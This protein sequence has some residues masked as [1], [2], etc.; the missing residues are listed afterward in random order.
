MKPESTTPSTPDTAKYRLMTADGPMGPYS[1][2]ELRLLVDESVV[3]PSMFA[4][5]EESIEQLPLSLILAAP[6]TWMPPQVT[7]S[8]LST[9]FEVEDRG[10][11]FGPYCEE[12]IR[13]MAAQGYFSF[14]ALAGPFG[15]SERWSLYKLLIIGRTFRESR[16]RLIRNRG[17]RLLGY[18]V[19]ALFVFASFPSWAVA[20]AGHADAAA[21]ASFLVIT[22]IYFAART[23][24][25]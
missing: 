5:S 13:L 12:T 11:T 23:P 16:E 17:M 19:G 20:F 7:P 18:A 8:R 15:T 4:I 14:E 1:A 3:D 21:I 25:L 6:D 24:P 22:G 2:S 10:R 9:L